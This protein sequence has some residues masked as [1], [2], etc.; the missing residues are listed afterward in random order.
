MDLVPKTSFIDA[1]LALL[2]IY[3]TVFGIYDHLTDS[4]ARKKRPL[5]SVALH[6]SESICEGSELYAFI[7]R[8][9]KDDIYKST[10]LNLTDFMKLPREIVQK[11][12]KSVN[13]KDEK[14]AKEKQAI[15]DSLSNSN[16][17]K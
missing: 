5:A 8:Y 11:I 16:T 13:T 9:I 1:K 12:F 6:E 3:E 2:D 4:Y 15:I 14:E 10:G 7:D 17:K